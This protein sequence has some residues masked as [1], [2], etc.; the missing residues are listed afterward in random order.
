MLG[1]G[2]ETIGM[3]DD[4]A[5]ILVPLA[6]RLFVIERATGAARELA[7]GAYRDAQLSPDGQRVAFVR[8]GDLWVAAI[9]EPAPVRIAQHPTDA[10]GERG[11]RDYATPDAEA[12]AFGRDRGFWW[13]PDSQSIAFERCDARAVEPVA[14]ADPRRLGPPA[15]EIRTPRPGKPIATVDLGIVSVRGGAPRW[16]TWDLAHYP[17][18][19]RVVWPARGPLTLVAVGRSQTV[20]AVITIDAATGAARPVLVEKDTAW[21]ELAP[22]APVWLPDGSGFLWLT[23]A[24]GAWSL[25]RHAADG[26]HVATLAT[27]DF[28]IHRVAGVTPDG[29]DAI[30]EAAGDPR[31]QHVWRIPLAGGARVAL[32]AG[33]GVHTARTGHGVIAI[34][35]QLHAGGR[36]TAVLRPDGSRTELPSLAERPAAVPTTRIESL[37]LEDHAQLTAV[38]RPHAFDPGLRYPVVIRFGSAPDIKSVVD[39]LDTYVLDQWYADAGFIVV[40]SDGRGTIGRDRS[41]HRA[42]AGDVLTLPMNDQISALKRLGAHYPELDI[43][44][45]AALGGEQ[46]GHLATLAAMLHPDAFAAAVAVSPITDWELV[47]AATAERFLRTPQTNP[48]GYRRTNASAYAEQLTR[49]LLLFPSVPGSRISPAHAFSLIDAL[50]AAGKR[51]EIAL[52]PDR[53]DAARRVASSVLVAE[54]FRHQLG[55]PSRP[56]VMP[57]ARDE[58]EDEEHKEKAERERERAQ[59]RGSATAPRA[60]DNDHH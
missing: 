6:G 42:I 17:Y 14:V 43:H 3:S 47:D 54:F 52:L 28:G 55:P 41:W 25:E 30:A 13:S 21:V 16:V 8:D 60:D 29:R 39:A 56:A 50:S 57:A 32:T 35:S 31:E 27:A 1:A 38:T 12:R 11:A 24:S 15:S 22:D 9:G 58:D 5:R 4:G 40:R 7:V 10:P 53:P 48:E 59:R 51:A 36:V 44:R 37:L 18:L 46:G 34:S 49:P 33:G 2:I 45:V 23:E 20:A 19:A 26:A